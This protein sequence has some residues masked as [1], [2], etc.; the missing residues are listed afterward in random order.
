MPLG[1]LYL[2]ERRRYVR[3]SP[4]NIVIAE[5]VDKDVGVIDIVE[6]IVVVVV[7]MKV[8]M[9]SQSRFR[10]R[11]NSLV[12]RLISPNSPNHPCA[13]HVNSNKFL[14]NQPFQSPTPR[15]ARYLPKARPQV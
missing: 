12:V 5:D 2:I 9:V 15:L 14:P 3:P 6:V 8:K 10:W 1:F 11:Y 7:W 13:T 4:A